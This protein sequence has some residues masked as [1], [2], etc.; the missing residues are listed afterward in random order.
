MDKVR[1]GM[2]GCGTVACYGHLPALSGITD[3]VELV[4]VSDLSETRLAELKDKY[5]LDATYTDY[6]DLLAR[7]DI[8]AI[9]MA[10]P[11]PNH[12]HVVMDA[13]QAGKHV[14]GEKPIAPTVEQ[15]VEMVEAMERA[16]KLFAIN[17]E[18]RNSDPHPEM[19]RLLDSGAIG[20]LKVAR[21][22]GNWMGGRWA[23]DDRYKMLITEGLG[24]IV[25]CGIHY[26]DLGRWYSGS[27]YAEVV[28]RGT[29]IEDWP[30]PDH[31]IAT[32]RM[33]NGV[34]VLNENGWAYTHNTPEHEA[35]LRYDL[36]GTDGLISYVDWQCSIEGQKNIKELS[37]YTKGE[38]YRKAITTPAKAFDRMYTM[39]AESIR[40]GK[41]EGLP[42]GRDGVAALRAALE[43]LRQANGE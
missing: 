24:P 40:R 8:E 26:F 11:L 18:L 16:G 28:A 30:N 33:E 13:A 20:E 12:H 19:K 4:A 31:V 29:Y 6:R 41:L 17:F 7:D 38:C 2:I 22:V 5:G 32:C 36:I 10:V 9:G 1:I 39:F 3:V 34:M 35:N 27:E 14:F 43:A 37:V 42:S 25:D 15:G 21:F 23:G